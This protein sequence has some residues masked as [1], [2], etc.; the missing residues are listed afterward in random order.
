MNAF[1]PE[2]IIKTLNATQIKSLLKLTDTPYNNK[3]KKEEL[4]S[5][6][7]AKSEITSAII[8]NHLQLDKCNLEKKI[9]N[10]PA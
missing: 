7:V 4:G 1:Q 3:M 10:P 5:L 6:A 9:N 8:I 2:Q